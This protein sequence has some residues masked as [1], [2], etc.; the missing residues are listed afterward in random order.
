MTTGATQDRPDRLDAF[1]PDPDIDEQ[2]EARVRAPAT[3]AMK[4]FRK[5]DVNRSPLVWLIFNLRTLPTRLR[6]RPSP[7][8]PQRAADTGR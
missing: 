2:H 1:I 8:R 6:G 5:L 3:A 4:T 7:E